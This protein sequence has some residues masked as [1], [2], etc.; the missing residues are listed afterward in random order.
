MLFYFFLIFFSSMHV[1]HEDWFEQARF[2]LFIYVY[3]YFIYLFFYCTPRTRKLR[4][5]RRPSAAPAFIRR[6]RHSLKL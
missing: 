1:P 2:C 6:P 3:F 4:L 5:S